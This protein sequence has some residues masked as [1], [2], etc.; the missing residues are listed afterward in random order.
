M[1]LQIDDAV[2]H[3]M[4]LICKDVPKPAWRRQKKKQRLRLIG[5]VNIFFQFVSSKSKNNVVRRTSC[6]EKKTVLTFKNTHV[7]PND[8]LKAM[9]T[10]QS[11]VH[12]N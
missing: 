2:V 12:S 5:N 9:F 4:S 6:T 10:S 1:I 8:L 7:K 11:T 3:A